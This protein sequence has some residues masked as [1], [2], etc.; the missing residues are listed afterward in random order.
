M[1]ITPHNKINEN[2]ALALVKKDRHSV[3][4][5]EYKSW[6]NSKNRE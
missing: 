6:L 4:A 5:E 3:Q 1:T 2:M